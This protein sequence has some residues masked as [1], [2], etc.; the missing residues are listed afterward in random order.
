MIAFCIQNLILVVM[1]HFKAFLSTFF[2]VNCFNF[3]ATICLICRCDIYSLL[4]LRNR[5]HPF[6]DRIVTCDEKWMIYDNRGADL[7]SGCEQG[8][9]TKTFSEAEFTSKKCY[10]DSLVVYCRRHSL[11]LPE[12]QR[13]NYRGKVLPRNR[14]NAP[15]AGPYF[16][17]ISQQ[18]RVQSFLYGN[19]QPHVT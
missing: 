14:R 5:N 2:A 1:Y 18:K 6:L 10:S 4:M 19:G 12:S 15:E 11:Q 17:V 8:W 9:G 7:A 3:A 13:Y 16:S